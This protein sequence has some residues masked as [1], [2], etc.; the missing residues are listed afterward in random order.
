M[1]TPTRRSRR[2]K[3]ADELE[4]IL[5]GAF[6]K[7]QALNFAQAIWIRRAV[8]ELRTDRTH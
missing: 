3:T 2:R 4:E 5:A 7:G 1:R 8:R 6:I